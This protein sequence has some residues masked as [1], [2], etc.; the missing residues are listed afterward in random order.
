MINTHGSHSE[1]IFT[2][3]FFA[4]PEYKHIAELAQKITGLLEPE[5]L[6]LRAVI[7]KRKSPTLQTFIS[8]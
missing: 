5:E 8:G 6:I 4:M 1:F 7:V 3:N 2:A